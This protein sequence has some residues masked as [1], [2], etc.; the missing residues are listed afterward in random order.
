METHSDNINDLV[1]KGV[2]CFLSDYLDICSGERVVFFSDG[3]R[4]NLVEILILSSNELDAVAV[5]CHNSAPFDQVA[6]YLDEC[7]I[8]VLLEKTSSSYRKEIVDY[9]AAHYNSVRI[10][11]MFDFS[12][13]LFT[14]TFNVEKNVLRCLHKNL[15]DF[16]SNSREIRVK[17]TKGTD[18]EIGL[19]DRFGWIDSCGQFSER[20]PAIFPVAEVATYS[21]SVSGILVADGAINTNFGFYTDPRLIHAPVTMQIENSVVRHISCSDTVLEYFLNRYINTPFCDRVGEVGIGTNYGIME[22][23]PFLSHINERF[24]ALHLGFGANNQGKKLIDWNCDFH[25]DLILDSCD[26]WIDSSCVLSGRKFLEIARDDALVSRKLR[27]A[28]ADTI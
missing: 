27:V 22:F 20:K 10:A 12:Q 24:P 5:H 9:L 17:S 16:A 15:L 3:E 2:R 4:E 26:I 19:D 28:H 18:L 11:R 1:K 14:H 6:K 23:V 8:A 25:L 13:E 21:P 7:D